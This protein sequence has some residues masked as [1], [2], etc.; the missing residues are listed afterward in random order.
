VA[1]C[2]LGAVAP[3]GAADLAALT[4]RTRAAVVHL[5]MRGASGQELATG[6]G[7]LVSADG[8]VLTNYHVVDGARSVTAKLD[9]GR[10]VAVRGAL[11]FDRES[12]V[13]VLQ[14]EGANYPTLRLGSSAHLRP[15]DPVIVIGSPAGLRGTL[16]AGFVSAIRAEGA[17]D[18]SSGDE[19]GEYRAWSIQITAPISPGSSGSPIMTES[20]DVVAIAVGQVMEAQALN[21]GVP[22]ERAEAL[23]RQLAP[24]ATLRPFPGAPT[25]RS[26][27]ANLMISVGLF[28]LAGLALWLA[29]S[30]R[31][32]AR[33]PRPR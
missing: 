9:G 7:F 33:A 15:G 20:G 21:F 4:E 11:A 14:L 8:R 28:V 29:S 16:S 25:G 22:I 27:A 32:V 13:A 24:G 6:S 31:S 5:S 3:A 1:L 10:A 12:D 19:G 26:I 2:W 17:G 23:L 18:P 30:R